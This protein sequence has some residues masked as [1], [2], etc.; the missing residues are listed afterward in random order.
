MTRRE[1]EALVRRISALERR[2]VPAREPLAADGSVVWARLVRVMGRGDPEAVGHA[3]EDLPAW[4]ELRSTMDPEHV[5]NVLHTFASIDCNDWGSEQTGRWNLARTVYFALAREWGG[6]LA[7]PAVVAEIYLRDPETRPIHNCETCGYRIPTYVGPGYEEREA[8]FV[9][10]QLCD[11]RIRWRWIRL[12]T[13]PVDA[14]GYATAGPL[15]D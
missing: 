4:N 8:Y 9:R 13:S 10:C 15:Q 6:P 5:A 3:L 1:R 7:L 14:R 12:R 11:G 2:R